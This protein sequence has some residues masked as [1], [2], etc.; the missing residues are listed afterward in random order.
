MHNKNKQKVFQAIESWGKYYE[1]RI[2]FLIQDES[3]NLD[4]IIDWVNYFL[5]LSKQDFKQIIQAYSSSHDID[6]QEEC[7]ELAIIEFYSIVDKL[8]KQTSALTSIVEVPYSKPLLAAILTTTVKLSLKNLQAFFN[9]QLLNKHW[10]YDES[11]CFIAHFVEEDIEYFMVSYANGIVSI[12]YF[13]H[14]TRQNF[15]KSYMNKNLF[16]FI[17]L[18]SGDC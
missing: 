5:S 14:H 17:S 7:E 18:H 6:L 13:C 4:N 9:N 1:N 16:Y 12:C 10:K 8:I 11:D 15:H 3:T 2:N